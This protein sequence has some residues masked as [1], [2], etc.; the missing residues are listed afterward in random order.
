MP[1]L[2]NRCKLYHTYIT[3]SRFV[4]STEAVQHRRHV[5][6]CARKWCEFDSHVIKQ[7]VRLQ[8]LLEMVVC[9]EPCHVREACVLTVEIVT[10]R[11]TP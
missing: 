5:S 9:I 1:E 8:R 7:L 4:V 10:L 11:L 6:D 2:A 3:A